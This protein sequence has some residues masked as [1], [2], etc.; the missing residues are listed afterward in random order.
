M[1]KVDDAV[2]VGVLT[3]YDCRTILIGLHHPPVDRCLGVFRL[4]HGRLRP[5]DLTRIDGASQGREPLPDLACRI[6]LVDLARLDLGP[7]AG[8]D[9]LVQIVRN[10]REGQLIALRY[11]DITEIRRAS[12]LLAAPRHRERATFDRQHVHCVA[13]VPRQQVDHRPATIL[14]RQG[15]PGNG[16]RAI[17]SSGSLIEKRPPIL[18]VRHQDRNWTFV[19]DSIRIMIVNMVGLRHWDAGP[20]RTAFS[21][22]RLLMQIEADR[23][24]ENIADNTR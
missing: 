19:D 17:R 5:V 16:E 2:A 6:D 3:D 15:E 10:V 20:R 13:L 18:S 9:R 24:A 11:G 4:L 7:A 21:R 1:Y 23:D 12:E 14:R 22:F 8:A